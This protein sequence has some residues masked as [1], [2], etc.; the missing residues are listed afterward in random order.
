MVQTRAGAWADEEDDELIDKAE[1]GKF[2]TSE[3]GLLSGSI[4]RMKN[5]ISEIVITTGS[6]SAVDDARAKRA[7]SS[8][9]TIGDSMTICYAKSR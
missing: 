2:S 9:K 1:H 6:D 7:V 8:S 3:R 4:A 5:A